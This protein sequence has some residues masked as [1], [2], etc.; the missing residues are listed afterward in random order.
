MSRP[1]HKTGVRHEPT[2][3]QIFGHSFSTE[4]ILQHYPPINYEYTSSKRAVQARAL[5]LP[6]QPQPQ[7]QTIHSSLLI[8]FL[9]SRSYCAISLH[10]VIIIP[11]HFHAQFPFQD[12]VHRCHFCHSVG[13]YCRR[14]FDS[15]TT[16]LRTHRRIWT[17]VASYRSQRHWSWS[18]GTSHCMYDAEFLSA[19]SLSPLT[20]SSSWSFFRYPH[21]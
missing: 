16:F 13:L 15:T 4:K 21:W 7:R 11:F 6:L 1:R 2:T 9:S 20:H 18:R 12:E 17:Q 8:L 14:F 10:H 5:L 3:R 19:C